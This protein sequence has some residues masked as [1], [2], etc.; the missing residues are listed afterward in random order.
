MVSWTLFL[1]GLAL[2]RATAVQAVFLPA[3]LPD[4]LYTLSFD[5]NG[6]AVGE[7]V[8]V[9]ALDSAAPAAS[10]FFLDRRQRQN[11]PPPLPRSQSRCG[12]GGAIDLVQFPN[13]KAQLQAECDH[14]DMYPPRT[15]VVF[16]AGR[17]IAYFCNCKRVPAKSLL[18]PAPSAGHVLTW[19]R[20]Q[21]MPPTAAGGRRWRKPSSR[22]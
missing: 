11:N 12:T 16:T 1:S 9:R 20:L 3:G 17:S 13:A 19:G 6:T 5:A 10:R 14:G 22:S 8:L 21:S 15:A 4:G 2:L 7:P 18:A